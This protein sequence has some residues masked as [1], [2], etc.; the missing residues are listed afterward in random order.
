M[1]GIPQFI[2]DILARRGICGE[3]LERFFD[4][5]LSRLE[6][7]E[8]L[9]GA[10]K[11]AEDIL[12]FVEKK[13]RIVVFGDYDCDG[14]CA[15]AILT[16][17]L[18]AVS[19]NRDAIVPFLPK[20]LEEGYGMS[21]AAIRR[22]L[23]EV[24]DVSIVITVD[25][26]IASVEQ[27]RM[28]RARGIAVIVTDHH[29]PGEV[30]PEADVLVNP[31]VA[32]P[33][34]LSILCGAG[35]AFMLAGALVKQARERGLYAGP[36]LCAPLLVLAGLATVTDIMPL[37]GQNRILVAEALKRFPHDAPI[38]LKK[39][40]ARA[41]RVGLVQL[42]SKDFG[43][44]LGPRINAA[45]RVAS[46]LEALELLLESDDDI[47]E[48]LARI[49]DARNF[50]RKE[51]EQKMT[52]SAYGRIV[53]GAAAQVIDIPNGH[54]GVAGIVAAR[55]LE[56]LGGVSPVCV[57]AGDHG[58]ARAPN[59]FNIRDAFD[60]CREFLT[61]YG[62]HA[63]A[64]GFSVREGMVGAFR[65]KLCAYASKWNH[66]T[67][68]GKAKGLGD[69]DAWISSRDVNLETAAWVSRMEPFGEEN[70]V[71]IFGLRDVL[72]TA[73]KPLG[74]EG[75]HLQATVRPREGGAFRAVWWG[76]GDQVEM[77]RLQSH[78]PV[79][80]QFELIVSDYG[81]RHVELRLVGCQGITT[82]Q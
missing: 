44:T 20:R 62:G 8:A 35:V 2:V 16:N 55:I 72:L 32:A 73:I 49:V 21:E 39:L 60:A 65:E 79:D 4:P 33:A 17:V 34:S 25:N 48:E 43:F 52:E 23:L 13:R 10:A 27:V 26:G 67:P 69:V 57:I 51:E 63:A 6:S 81:E 11:A 12:S 3:E 68:A 64:G 22:M 14:I 15:T 36:S 66:L 19:A 50:E 53:P 78:R 71:P 18:R 5:S 41:S 37:T 40:L 56:K 1:E 58:S 70:D 54:P 30:L 24:P 28:L 38:G 47:A 61:C 46:G 59:G 75:R 82:C 74:S 77:F 7:P 29:L 45:G 31:K 76:K 80:V 9:P 42:T